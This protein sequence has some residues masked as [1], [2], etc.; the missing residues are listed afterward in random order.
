MRTHFRKRYRPITHLGVL[1]LS[2]ATNRLR[3]DRAAQIARNVTVVVLFEESTES[4]LVF[5][6]NG[7]ISGDGGSGDGERAKFDRVDVVRF[8]VLKTEA[9]DDGLDE[10]AAEFGDGVANLLGLIPP[11][12]RERTETSSNFLPNCKSDNAES[13]SVEAK[14]EMENLPR[15][16]FS[17]PSFE[18]S[19][20]AVEVFA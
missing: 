15:F 12:E 6:E 20:R 5:C 7:F 3:E 18:R 9:I 19:E 2:S 17:F 14:H 10:R 11:G 16:S 1:L 4:T 8:R 13:G